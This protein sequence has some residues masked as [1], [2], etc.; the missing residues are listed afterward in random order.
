MGQLEHMAEHTSASEVRLQITP[1]SVIFLQESDQ[2]IFKLFP[3]QSP[4]ISPT[5]QHAKI[6]KL[7]LKTYLRTV[8]KNGFRSRP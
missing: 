3:L 6:S 5:R 8:K 7:N 1:K 2:D 4:Q